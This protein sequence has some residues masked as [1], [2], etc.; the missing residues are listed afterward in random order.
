MLDVRLGRR[1]IEIVASELEKPLVQD[2][3]F[4]YQLI[5]FEMIICVSQT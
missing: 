4:D 2:S 1:S 5:P 3:R